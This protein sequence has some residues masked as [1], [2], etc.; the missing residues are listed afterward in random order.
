MVEECE[1]MLAAITAFKSCPNLE[2]ADRADLDDWL[3]RASEDFAAG[4]KANPEPNAQKAIALAC[5]RATRSVEAAHERC[6]VGPPPKDAW[7]R[8]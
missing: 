5:Q 2:P 7:Y 1:A 8:R 4:R 6:L 3:E